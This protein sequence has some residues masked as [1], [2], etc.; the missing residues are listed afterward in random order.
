M[1]ISHIFAERNIG[2]TLIVTI[3][4]S[5]QQ[6]ES[7]MLN[8]G[9]DISG[10]FIIDN[11]DIAVNDIRKCVEKTS[12]EIV[13]INDFGLINDTEVIG[14]FEQL[15]KDYSIPVMVSIH[16]GRNCGDHD[17]MYRR[18]Q[19]FDLIFIRQYRDKTLNEFTRDFCSPDTT[20][21]FLHRNHDCERGIGAAYRYNIGDMAELIT[22]RRTLV[23]LVVS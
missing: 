20:I 10:T 1:Y 15:S 5:K 9:Y 6:W 22:N 3:E 18:P 12:P 13:M 8:Y 14:K 19:L 16:L 4:K 17:P 7:E 11:S 23:T 2:K 21:M